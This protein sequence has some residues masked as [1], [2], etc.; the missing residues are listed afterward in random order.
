MDS[1]ARSNDG[2]LATTLSRVVGAVRPHW[3]AH[4]S[5]LFVVVAVSVTLFRIYACTQLPVNTGDVLRHLHYGL[6]VAQRGLST[7]SL[8]LVQISPLYSNV[9]WNHIPYNYPVVTLLFFTLVARILP[10]VFFAKLALTCLE[11]ASSLLILR[12]SRDKWLALLYWIS[13]ISVWWVS[14][15][16]QFES[17]Q[18]FLVILALL[19]LS[20]RR[21]SSS[22]LLLAL[23]VQVKLSAVLLLPFFVLS[24][25]RQIGPLRYA[26]SLTLGLAP[27]AFVFLSHPALFRAMSYSSSLRFNPYYWNFTDLTI[28]MWMNYHKWLIVCNQ[29]ASYTVLALLLYIAINQKRVLEL[30]APVAFLALVKTLRN[31][32]FWYLELFPSFVLPLRNLRMR[33]LLFFLTPLLD[34][35]SMSLCLVSSLGFHGSFF[36]N[37]TP[38][39][40]LRSL[41]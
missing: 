10:T 13:P 12:Y 20:K 36:I 29:I 27:S 32:Q 5:A 1:G 9:V 37:V 7:A 35:Y 18:S 33:R 23:A 3:D 14:H 40:V 39:T 8:P 11:A 24:I 16:G 22:L 28:F 38:F 41:I 2:R 19:L 17:L 6:L 26:A 31:V 25:R 34:V 15:E 4:S 21:F 30:L